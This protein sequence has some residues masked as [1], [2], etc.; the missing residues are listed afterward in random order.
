MDFDK[1]RN[2]RVFGSKATSVDNV[3]KKSQV[4]SF[5]SISKRLGKVKVILDQWLMGLRA[6]RWGTIET[7]ASAR[8]FSFP[9]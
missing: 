9:S 1:N 3:L 7:A 8:F 4:T 6:A 5:D 2:A